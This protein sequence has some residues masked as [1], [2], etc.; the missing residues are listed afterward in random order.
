[1]CGWASV[2]VLKRGEQLHAEA[3]RRFTPK[4]EQRSVDRHDGI[5]PGGGP[6]RADPATG[7]DATLQQGFRKFDRQINGNELDLLQHR[8]VPEAQVL[9]LILFCH[10]WKLHR[11]SVDLGPTR[12]ETRLKL[13]LN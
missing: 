5:A 10:D 9:S 7:Q 3:G 12:V 6:D 8:D 2:R 4:R 13:T 1:M 11:P